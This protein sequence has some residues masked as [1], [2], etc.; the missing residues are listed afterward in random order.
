MNNQWSKGLSLVGLMVLVGVFLTTASFLITREFLSSE[1]S[2]S[3][4]SSSDVANLTPAP[5]PVATQLTEDRAKAKFA[6]D[7]NG[8]T[9]VALGE[10]PRNRPVSV[11]GGQASGGEIQGD[12]ARQRANGSAV[13]FGIEALPAGYR[14]TDII[15]GVCGPIVASVAR[16]FVDGR[17]PPIDV[18][19]FA[20]QPAFPAE[21]PAERLQATTIA[22]HRA[23]VMHPI[24][25]QGIAKV[26]VLEGDGL[27]L[28]QGNGDPST[29]VGVAERIL[30]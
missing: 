20:W 10:T 24:F 7:F 13:D 4:Q 3:A 17:N 29:L 23:V 22:G 26:F 18:T 30:D 5:N 2:L 8:V 9:F 1:Q 28:V 11:C 27:L 12:E 15:T 19:R 25:P 16:S 6:G 21:A 14:E